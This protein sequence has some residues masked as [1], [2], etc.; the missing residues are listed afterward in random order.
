MTSGREPPRK[1][2]RSKT[3]SSNSLAL[4]ADGKCAKSATAEPTCAP[5]LATLV[6][7]SPQQFPAG[8]FALNGVEAELAFTLARDLP[9]RDELYT[10]AEMPHVLASVHVAIEVV[11]SRF[12]DIGATGSLSLLAD[13]QSNGALVLGTGVA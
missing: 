6:L 3:A 12:F 13:F 10:E 2:T 9:L 11:D 4:L 5:L 7:R 1:R 8:T